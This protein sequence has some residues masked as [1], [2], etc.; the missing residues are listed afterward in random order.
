MYC[1]YIE[2][3]E[4][5]NILKN[6]KVYLAGNMEHT[7]GA[8][9]WREFVKNRL[10]PSKINILSPLDTKF[11]GYPLE[12]REDIVNM[13]QER[14]RGNFKMVSNYMKNVIRKD[15]RLIDLS[16]FVIVNMEVLKP[17]FGT[18]HELVIAGQ[19]KKPIFVSISEGKKECPLWILGLVDPEFIFDN[20][21]SV[22]DVILKIDDGSIKMDFERWRLLEDT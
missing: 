14:A 4:V 7:S 16:D 19:Q 18:M 22:V 6:S 20:I 12:S 2:I 21:E 3:F 15:L 9:G 17:T 11:L 5:N 13:K 10:R 1:C 8:E